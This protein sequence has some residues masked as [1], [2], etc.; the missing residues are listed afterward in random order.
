MDLKELAKLLGLPED[1][2]EEEVKKAAAV[3]A[4]AKKDAEEKEGEPKEQEPGKDAGSQEAVVPVANS[5]VL[6]L[7][8]LDESAKTED[9]AASIMALKAGD[10]NVQTELLVLKERLEK[11]EAEDLVTRALKTG[12][13][14]AAQKDWAEKYALSNKEEFQNFLEKAPVVVPVEKLELKDAPQNI[15]VDPLILKAC[16]TNKEDFEKYG[17]VDLT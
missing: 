11:Q 3:A 8:G 2:T 4:K 14:T 17:K 12:K 5:T 16:G 1:A 10:V 7:L 15:E 6:S 13:I 9:V